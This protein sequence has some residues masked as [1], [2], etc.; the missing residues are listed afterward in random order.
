MAAVRKSNHSRLILILSS[1]VLGSALGITVFMTFF[2]IKKSRG[3][4]VAQEVTE[5]GEI[6]KKIHK[7]AVIKSIDHPRSAINF[8]NVKSFAGSTV[9]PLNLE[10][11][12]KWQ[13]P[14]LKENLTIQTNEYEL[15]RTKNGFVIVPG[16][17]T[18]LPN[19]KVVGKD[20]LFDENS[21][22][23]ALTREGGDLYFENRPLATIID[24]QQVN[25][26]ELVAE[27]LE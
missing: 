22:F 18:T 19:G 27:E 20:V 24:L 9:G 2:N 14:Y 17:G 25:T 5:L 21:D 4:L 7:T 11:P 26:A 3:E 16:V 13:G 12:D 15:V 6:F 1:L 10:Y 8:L 23:V